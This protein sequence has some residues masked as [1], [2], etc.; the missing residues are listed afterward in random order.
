MLAVSI[1]L[2]QLE[3]MDAICRNGN[4]YSTLLYKMHKLT[5]SIIPKKSWDNC[6][7]CK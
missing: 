1:P 6:A 3:G 7:K 2:Y 4:K 5:K